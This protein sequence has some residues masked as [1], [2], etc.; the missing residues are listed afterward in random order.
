AIIGYV[1]AV[2]PQTGYVTGSVDI[3]FLNLFGSARKFGFHWQRL[4]Q[5][6]QDLWATYHE[7]WV[8]GLPVSVDG[9]V[10]QQEQDTLYTRRSLQLN[11]AVL[12]ADHFTVSGMVSF[13]ST[14][15]GSADTTAQF[16]SSSENSAG[17]ELSYDTRD[18][19]YNPRS[20]VLYSSGYTA[21]IK[22][23]AGAQGSVPIQ[24]VDVNTEAYY[25]FIPYSVAALA[26]HG[27]SV[28]SSALDVSD[29]YRVGGVNSIRGYS[30]YQFHAS[31]LLWG[32]AEYRIILSDL[33]F[34][35]A[36]TDIGYYVQTA[37][38]EQPLQ[39]QGLLMGYGVS[40]QVPSAL[41]LL[42]VSFAIPRGEPFNQAKIHIGVVNRF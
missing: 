5:N 28:S 22:S 37:T 3:S 42:R 40:I 17:A 27:S 14:V 23:V 19:V 13:I 4:Q 29:M 6:S 9:R 38:T 18:N 25:E 35:S 26:L 8:F 11:A 21:G 12:F 32:T 16:P 30:D 36:F 24:T 10:E 39:Q 7:P 2:A 20:G 15:P 31:R 1:P 33:S 34:A 41:G